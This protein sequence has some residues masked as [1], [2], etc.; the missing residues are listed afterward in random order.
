MGGE[1]LHTEETQGLF[2]YPMQ[3]Y[4]TSRFLKKSRTDCILKPI[5]CKNITLPSMLLYSE[6]I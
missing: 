5:I 2:I 3:H 6:A 4:Q 1:G